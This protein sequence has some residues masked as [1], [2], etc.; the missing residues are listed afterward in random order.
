VSELVEH[1]RGPLVQELHLVDRKHPDSPPDLEQLVGAGDR[2]GGKLPAR[3]AL[4]ERHRASSVDDRLGRH[5]VETSGR[6]G[7]HPPDQPFRL[8]GVHWADEQLDRALSLLTHRE[9]VGGIVERSV[10]IGVSG[11]SYPSWKPG[12][13]P[14]GTDSADFLGYYAERF[15]TVELNTTGYRIPAEEQFRRWAEKTPPGFTFAP[16]LPANRRGMLNDFAERVGALGDRL[17]P[18]RIV[19]IGARDEGMIELL[20]GSLDPA[21]RLAFDLRDPTWDGIEPLL[22]EAGAVRV[23]DV[24]APARFRYLRFRDPPYDD[25]ALQAQAA[26]IA[27]LREPVYAYFRHEDEPTAPV[28]A[29]RLRALLSTG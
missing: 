21:L 24:E 26:R 27:A 20:L 19:L 3:V 6:G 10:H 15:H 8:P 1:R 14:A 5:D 7:R 2:C 17:G 23:D 18:I 4:D 11:W 9:R 25:A 22:A 12:F 28:Y 16:K 13:Y 29:E